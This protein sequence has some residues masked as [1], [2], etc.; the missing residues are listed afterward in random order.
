MVVR[1]SGGTR[2][3]GPV[4]R[5]IAGA[6]LVAALFLLWTTTAV[7]DDDVVGR[8]T[9][10]GVFTEE[11]AE[12]ARS[13]Y[14]RECAVCHGNNLGGT[15]NAP[16]LRGFAFEFF[17]NGRTL[18]EMVTYTQSTMPLTSPGSLTQSNVVNLVALILL[19]NG[20]EAG[21]EALPADLE[22][23]E[24]ITFVEPEDEE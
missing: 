9:L 22:V 20:F 18:A 3:G 5:V 24:S 17:W 7:A 6:A 11:Q 8:T 13:T 23:L 12:G 4:M 2:R 1:R 16:A 21:D 19:E 15:A 14:A 10:D